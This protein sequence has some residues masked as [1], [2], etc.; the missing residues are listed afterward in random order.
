MFPSVEFLR[1]L[2]VGLLM[3]L[4][5]RVALLYILAVGWGVHAVTD[6]DGVR[7]IPVCMI[8]QLGKP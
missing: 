1:L 4:S 5:W 7:K 8:V 6:E 3:D 2:C